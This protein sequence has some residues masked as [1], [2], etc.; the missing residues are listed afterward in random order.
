MG[1]SGWLVG[2]LLWLAALGVRFLYIHANDFVAAGARAFADLI[3][4]PGSAAGKS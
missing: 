2:G 3:G 4:T 1:R